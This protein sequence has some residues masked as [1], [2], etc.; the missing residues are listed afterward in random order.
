MDKIVFNKKKIHEVI[1]YDVM[2]VIHIGKISFAS[3]EQNWTNKLFSSSLMVKISAL[4]KNDKEIASNET[5]LVI[6]AFITPMHK[7]PV[8]E[9]KTNFSFSNTFN[10]DNTSRFKKWRVEV[11]LRNLTLS[12]GESLVIEFMDS[13]YVKKRVDDWERRIENLILKLKDWSKSIP[14]LKI[15]DARRQKMHEGFMKEFNISM[16]EIPSVDILKEGKIIMV[17]KPFGLWIMGAN[18]RID[19]LTANGNNILV[20]ISKE[21]SEARWLLY[22]NGNHSNGIAF[23]PIE[24]IKLLDL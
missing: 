14:G 19:L 21:F 17:V 11:T 9:I 13:N 7:Q 15:K 12:D 23:T 20:D 22:H 2:P 6:G 24:F 5:P 18:G 10:F 3:E 4:D 16:R 8:F 1:S